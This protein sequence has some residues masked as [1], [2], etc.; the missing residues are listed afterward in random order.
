M[1]HVFV[2]SQS[3]SMTVQKLKKLRS[4]CIQ[5]TLFLEK[6]CATQIVGKGMSF[7]LCQ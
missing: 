2:A 1:H 6:T 7:H 4:F 5:E 3:N